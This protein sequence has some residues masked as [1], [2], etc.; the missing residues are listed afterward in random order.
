MLV[1]PLDASLADLALRAPAEDL[2]Q[3]GSARVRATPRVVATQFLDLRAVN[4]PRAGEGGVKES[5]HN[6]SEHP[7]RNCILRRPND[8][9]ISTH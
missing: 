9:G 5:G 4:W 3:E 6:E 1:L 7:G 2:A 8:V